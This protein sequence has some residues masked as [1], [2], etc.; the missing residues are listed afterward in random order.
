[1]TYQEAL[2]YIY[3]SLPMFHRTGKAA[4]KANLDNTHALDAHFNYPHKNF[5]TIHIAGTNGKGSVSHMIASV[6]QEAGY[7]TGLYTSPHLKDFR[8]RIKINGVMISEKNIADFITINKAFLEEIKPSFFEMTVALAFDFFA[9]EK[10][11]IA[12]VEVGLGGRLDSTNIISPEL[13]VI[14]N[15][16]YDHTDLLGDTLAKIAVEKAG[17]IKKN[18]PVLIGEKSYETSE[19]FIEKSKE[20][21]AP[22]YFAEEK[23]SA[24]PVGCDSFYQSFSICKNDKTEFE[25]VLIDLPGSYQQKNIVTAI[26]AIEIL[27]EKGF[28]INRENIL[29]GLKNAAAKTGLMGR[30][31]VLSE[32]PLVV[33]D[34]GHNE[35]GMKYIARQ[36]RSVSYKKLHIVLGAVNDKDIDSMLSQLPREAQYY[37]TKAKIP[38]ALDEQILKEK[39]QKFHLNG[40]TFSSVMEALNA[41]K[42]EA[43]ENDMIF[44]GG[45]T[46]VV[47]EVI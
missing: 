38:R 32:N 16:S 14:T 36:I 2:D 30:W 9:K 35:A 43:S 37:F 10:I 11:D 8:E 23:F 4:Y 33:C 1:M 21:E 13:S 44:I 28:R 45:S 34:T 20:N 6:L 22:I 29:S 15:I 40:H 47:A 12:V 27:I 46:F 18:I 41:A 25:N 26:S 39:A 17:I 5:K 42:S 31:Q 19:I 7:K 24:K 3:N